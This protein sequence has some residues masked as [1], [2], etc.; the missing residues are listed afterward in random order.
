MRPESVVLPPPAISE[1]LS[2]RSR[3]EQL[4]VEE[5]IPEP[6]VVDEVER[7]SYDSAK[8]FSQGDPGSMLVVVVPL[9]SHQ[10][11]RAWA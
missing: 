5:L 9:P 7:S 8:P 3:G 4:R 11:R 6:A 2:L 10:L 1:E